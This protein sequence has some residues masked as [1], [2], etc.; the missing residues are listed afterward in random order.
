MMVELT[1]FEKD[2]IAKAS[3]EK[4]AYI[5]SGKQCCFRCRFSTPPKNPE[6][7]SHYV[8]CAWDVIV[9]QPSCRDYGK[10]ANLVGVTDGKACRVWEPKP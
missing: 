10:C 7:A 1:P 2:L 4:E 5:A 8:L 6:D 3:A 9:P